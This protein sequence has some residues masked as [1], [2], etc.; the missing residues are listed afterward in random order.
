VRT[1]FDGLL[2][3]LFGD[4]HGVLLPPRIGFDIND[5]AMMNE[6][7]H[8]SRDTGEAWEDRSSLLEGKVGG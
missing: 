8:E 1:S 6:T 7:V 4:L 2:G 3:F 5:M